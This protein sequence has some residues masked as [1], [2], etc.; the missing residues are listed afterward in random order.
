MKK[1]YQF[2]TVLLDRSTEVLGLLPK[3]FRRRAAMNDQSIQ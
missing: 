1:Q 3:S 2:I